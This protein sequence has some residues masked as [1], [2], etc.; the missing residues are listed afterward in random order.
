[1]SRESKFSGAMVK[2]ELEAALR[3]AGLSIRDSKTAVSV[4][5]RFMDQGELGLEPG[6]HSYLGRFFTK[7][8]RKLNRT[9]EPAAHGMCARRGVAP[10]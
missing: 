4:F 5:S 6:K 2:R 1:M 8:K 7:L 9:P 3:E 10:S